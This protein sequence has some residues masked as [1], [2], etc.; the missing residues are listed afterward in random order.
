MGNIPV[1]IKHREV[2][3]MNKIV[4]QTL[5]SEPAVLAANIFKT[6]VCILA[7]LFYFL[8]DS[9]TGLINCHIMSGCSVIQF[10][11]Y[12]PYLDV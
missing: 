10:C 12:F 4:K 8:V 6:L 1:Y 9:Y 11:I 3:G 2:N 7:Q 5:D